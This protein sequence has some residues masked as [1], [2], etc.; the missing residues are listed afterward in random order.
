MQATKARKTSA[1]RC[2]QVH[3]NLT[4]DEF[5]AVRMVIAD[6]GHKQVSKFLRGIVMDFVR[7]RFEQLRRAGIGAG[8]VLGENGPMLGA[9]DGEKANEREPLRA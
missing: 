8:I 9:L 6:L 4:P 2:E 5:Y 7:P 3:M 1:E